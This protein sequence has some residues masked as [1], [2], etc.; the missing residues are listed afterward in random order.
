[1]LERALIEIFIII[2]NHIATFAIEQ[3]SMLRTVIV[4]VRSVQ[5]VS[6]INHPN[7]SAIRDHSPSG[8]LAVWPSIALAG[9]R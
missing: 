2:I 7:E 9:H 5:T 4:W 8:S 3:S 1:L 6:V